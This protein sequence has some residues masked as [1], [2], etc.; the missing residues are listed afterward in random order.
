SGQY[1]SRGQ[2]DLVEFVRRE[3]ETT[4]L[5][6]KHLTGRDPRRQGSYDTVDDLVRLCARAGTPPASY[7]GVWGRWCCR[8]ETWPASRGQNA[9]GPV[10]HPLH[11]QRPCGTASGRL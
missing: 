1:L 10:G 11:R 8:G 9:P 3:D 2:L 7:S 5:V 4:V 6:D